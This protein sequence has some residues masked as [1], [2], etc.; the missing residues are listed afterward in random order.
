[1][2]DINNREEYLVSSE[3]EQE[4]LGLRLKEARE[5]LGMSQEFVA[6]QLGVPRASISTMETS[7]R[8]VSS[9]ELKQLAR[10]YKQTIQYFLGEEEA[11]PQGQPKDEALS[12]LFRTTKDLS[13][14]DKQQVLRFAQFLRASGPAPK[15]AED[16]A[17]PG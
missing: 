3:Q 14:E 16:Q 12:A 4:A 10:L 2:S 5:Y 1:M 9:L 8:K 17:T 15:P 6:E 11:M 7:K 13:S